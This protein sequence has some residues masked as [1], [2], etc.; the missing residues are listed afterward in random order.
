MMSELLRL[1][2]ILIK[3]C[4]TI[5]KPVISSL[6]FLLQTEEIGRGIGNTIIQATAT[7]RGRETGIIPTTNTAIRITTV[8]GV[9]TGTPTAAQAIIATTAPL[10]KGRMTSTAT[11]G[12]TGVTDLIMT[13]ERDSNLTTNL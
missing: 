9:L 12:T 6:H 8:T 11:T 10:E 1:T 13:G 3:Q 2:D 4:F 5:I 7:S